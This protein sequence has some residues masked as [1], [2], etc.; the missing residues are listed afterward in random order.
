MKTN[1]GSENESTTCTY[2]GKQNNQCDTKQLQ[3]PDKKLLT[4]HVKSA[5]YRDKQPNDVQP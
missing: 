4:K 1:E 5:E 2:A 3:K